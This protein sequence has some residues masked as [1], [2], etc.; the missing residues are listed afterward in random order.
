MKL[1]KV[2]QAGRGEARLGGAWLGEARRGMAGLVRCGLER[3]RK[4]G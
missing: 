2:W 4:A 1:G 3:F